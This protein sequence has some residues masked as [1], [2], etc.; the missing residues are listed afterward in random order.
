MELVALLVGVRHPPPPPYFSVKPH[1]FPL[2]VGLRI[3][4]SN[5]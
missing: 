2:D 4:V 3:I 5:F 1:W